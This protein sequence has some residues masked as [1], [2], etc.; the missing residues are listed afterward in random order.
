MDNDTLLRLF[1][2]SFVLFD[3][4]YTAWEGSQERKWSGENEYRE[5]IQI[6]AIRVMGADFREEGSFLE[7]VKPVKNPLLSDFITTLTGI[8]Q[9]DI[10]A[11]GVA[12]SDALEALLAFAEDLPMY[13]WGRDMEVLTENCRLGAL[14]E[15]DQLSRMINM[16]PILAPVFARAGVDIAN[17]SSGTLIAAFEQAGETRR[18]HDAL[19]DMRNLREALIALNSRLGAR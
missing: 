4:E 19:N 12:F 7:Y 6:G 16:R 5:V 1:P 2:E 18:A 9:H 10:D 11:K 14:S 17:Y 8:T 3:L 15:P 13:C